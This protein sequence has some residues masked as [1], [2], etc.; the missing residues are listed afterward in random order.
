V[1]T[2]QR[3][4]AVRAGFGSGFLG[5]ITVNGKKKRPKAGIAKK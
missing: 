3:V 2:V 1:G 5:Q 4:A